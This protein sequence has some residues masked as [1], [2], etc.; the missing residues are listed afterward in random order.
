MNRSMILTTAL[1]AF[2]PFSALAQAEGHSETGEI[3]SAAKDEWRIEFSPYLFAPDVDAKS[4][5]SGATSHVKLDFGDILDDFAIFGL[6]GRLE[7]WKGDWGLFL[8]GYYTNLEGDFTLRA[9]TPTIT[10]GTETSEAILDF[11][12]GHRLL[13]LPLGEDQTRMLTGDILGGGRYHYLKQEIELSVFHPV[14]GGL[15]TTL[16]GD[17]EWV[18]LIVGARI[19]C[20]IFDNFAVVVRGDIGGFGIGSGSDLTWNVLA[21]VD[22]RF[23]ENMS[24]K[25]GYRVLDIDYERGSGRSR[26]GFDGQ[27]RGP[28]IG[29]TISF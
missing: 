22:W 18:E 4:T 25:V 8:D 24:L 20:D 17:E 2:L 27:M 29:L 28:I 1:L 13:K 16:G 26:F 21:G 15:G 11:G 23:R 7:V 6:S 19:K 9:P 14:L 5:V 3:K 12:L 10:V